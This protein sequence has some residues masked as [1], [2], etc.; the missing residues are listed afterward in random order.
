MS[1]LISRWSGLLVLAAAAAFNVGSPSAAAARPEAVQLF[2]GKDL[3]SFYTWLV[4]DKYTDP[5]RVFSVVDQIDGAPAIRVSGE[6]YGAFITRN[7]Y[8][9]YH[10]VTEYRWGNLT[11]ANRKNSARDSGILIHCQGPDGNTR[12]DF[13]GPWMLSQECQIIEGGT[14]DFILVA[15]HDKD[16]NRIVPRLTVTARKEQRP[17]NR[18]A[19]VYDPT[20]PA[21]EFQGGRIDWWGRDPE[22][23]GVLGFRGRR[24]V[25]SPYQAWTRLE[26][27]CDGDSITNIVNGQVVNKGTRS[28]L[29]KGKII[30][31]S[32]GAE[33]YFR[34]VELT[35][36]R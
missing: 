7:E 34:K 2:N 24:D 26:V 14:G 6:K 22:Y 12:P 35:P 23:Q 5:S 30:F 10:L 3:S 25:E 21:V 28:S 32:E 11:W 18:T 4:N 9:D 13:N 16:G 15:G 17:N 31:Q 20:A 29:T 1:H 33:L 27:I 36:L 8:A 19:N